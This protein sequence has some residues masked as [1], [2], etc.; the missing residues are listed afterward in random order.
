MPSAARGLLIESRT[1]WF[2][3]ARPP[4][5]GSRTPHWSA[6][7]ARRIRAIRL[8]GESRTPH[9]S[10]VPVRRGARPMSSTAEPSAHRRPAA[11]P[12][13]AGRCIGAQ[14]PL[15]IAGLSSRRR[16]AAR[17]ARR[18]VHMAKAGRCIGTWFLSSSVGPSAHRRSAAYQTG[19]CHPLARRKPNAALERG[20]YPT[21]HLPGKCRRRRLPRGRGGGM[22]PAVNV[23]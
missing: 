23:R 3:E 4:P 11:R 8:P 2:I 19:R 6:V 13:K 21:P 10:T 9:W 14:P 15:G 12:V 16:P 1:V 22:R 20:S 17:P 18:T 7:L 5:G